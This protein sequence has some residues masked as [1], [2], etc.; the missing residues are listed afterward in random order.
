MNTIPKGW[1]TTVLSTVARAVTS[2]PGKVKPSPENNHGPHEPILSDRKQTTAIL[3]EQNHVLGQ[4][5]R[6]SPLSEVL[7]ALCRMVE[8]HSTNGVLASILI[9][10]PHRPRLTHGA[11]PSLPDAY[12]QAIEGL[13]I[14]PDVG[15]CGA[16][17][18]RRQPV[19]VADIAADQLWTNHAGLALAHGLAACWSQPILSGEG[20]VLGTFAMYYTSARQPAA[21][22]LRLVATIAQTAAIAIERDRITQAVRQRTNQFI[23]LLNEAPLGV[24]L[25]DADFLIR[26]VNPTALAVFGDIPDLIGRDFNEVIRILWPDEYA[27]YITERFRRTL[28]TGEPFTQNKHIERR[29]DRGVR[30]CYEWQINRIPLPDGRHG[31]VC[32]FR[33]IS[34]QVRTE[35]ALRLAHDR[36]QTVLKN[37]PITLFTHD[38]ELR[39]TW[40]LNSYDG[41]DEI[42]GKTD[43]EVAELGGV[44]SVE[45]AMDLMEFKTRVLQTGVGER[46]EQTF[47]FLGELKTYD[48]TLEPIRD[49]NGDVV[50]LAGV[51]LDISERKKAEE[52]FRLESSKTRRIIDSNIIGVLFANPERIIDA[53]NAFLEMVGYSDEDLKAGLLVWRDMT[54][55]EHTAVDN[56]AV[57]E[58]ER[59]GVASPWQ[60]EF[61]RKDGTR[62]PVMIGAAVFDLAPTWV[63]FVQDMSRVKEVENEL[64]RTDRRKDEFLAMLA[65]ELRNPL[66]AISNAVT[67]ATHGGL[68]EHIDWSIDVIKRQVKHLTRLIDDLLD[69]SRINQGKIEL[70]KDLLE[71]TPLLNS[72]VATVEPLLNERKHTLDVAIDRGN[73]WVH[74]DPTRLEQVMINL[75]NNAAKYSENQGHVWLHAHNEP[76]A[77]VVTVGDKGIGIPPDQLPHMFELFVQGGRTLDRSEG[78]LGIGLTVVKRLVQMHGGVITAKSEGPGKGSEFTIRLPAATPLEVAGESA[79]KPTAS[80]IGKSRI[81]I[82]DDNVDTARSLARLLAII[83]HDVATAYSGPEAIEVARRQRPAFIL[84]DIGLPGMD[85]YEVALKLRQEECCTNATVVAVSGYGKEEDR[86]RS[87]EAG[88]DHHLTKPLDHDLLLSLISSERGSDVV[89]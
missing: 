2:A 58:L 72:A 19:H 86:R 56:K 74:A 4:I 89:A 18:Y 60:K 88:F 77:V 80:A 53:N 39:T 28:E 32:Y 46:R 50:G 71:L 26:E 47:T 63:A 41:S 65:H 22:D 67:I 23:T 76:N 7:D 81:L 85:G 6:G 55:A 83:G 52:A 73:L 37:A 34:E 27:S 3:E 12:N 68:S 29:R 21:D 84:L 75:L 16:A 35:H 66:A 25:V 40:V 42:I 82:V 30:E 87:R 20:D 78:G 45:D 70:R 57:D 64:R 69:V 61:L 43:L 24:Y 1:L 38:R 5:A 48:T 10:D 36:F 15:S 54:P 79:E 31:V 59:L 8:K 33:D 44:I 49:A 9:L 62:V 51:S 17:A 14:G 11:A 13:V